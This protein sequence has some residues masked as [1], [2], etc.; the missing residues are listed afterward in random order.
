MASF[1]QVS[2]WSS[3]PNWKLWSSYGTGSVCWVWC[4]CWRNRALAHCNKHSRLRWGC[5]S[6]GN[7]Q[8]AALIVCSV[9]RA[10][11]WMQHCWPG[12]GRQSMQISVSSGQGKTRIWTSLLYNHSTSPGILLESA[13]A[14]GPACWNFKYFK[15]HKQ[16][17]SHL[18]KDSLCKPWHSMILC[19]CD[20]LLLSVLQMLGW[21]YCC[22]LASSFTE[23][24]SGRADLYIWVFADTHRKPFALFVFVGSYSCRSDCVMCSTVLHSSD[25][26]FLIAPWVRFQ[27]AGSFFT[28]NCLFKCSH[29]VN[30]WH[31]EWL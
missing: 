18:H 10:R 20:K 28:L 25:C 29:H 1:V 3:L 27:T 30:V 7:P 31:V 6:G 12:V 24:Q 22:P 5:T 2:Q 16:L 26:V 8:E 23:Q 13:A 21:N 9:S 14:A 19:R 4:S 17:D 11:H 15:T